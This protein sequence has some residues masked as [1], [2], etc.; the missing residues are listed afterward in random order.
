M[1]Q[2]ISKKHGWGLPTGWAGCASACSA[3]AAGRLRGL[4]VRARALRDKRTVFWAYLGRK[5]VKNYSPVYM[6]L[7]SG[8]I[9]FSSSFPFSYSNFEY[10]PCKFWYVNMNMK[11]STQNNFNTRNHINDG[12]VHAWNCLR[13]SIRDCPRNFWLDRIP[14]VDDTHYHFSQILPRNQKNSIK[15]NTMSMIRSKA[16]T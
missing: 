5:P 15:A 13:F 14:P 1:K 3:S 11:M 6:N 9:L 8:F 7:I 12:G 16:A 2:N 10:P 4:S